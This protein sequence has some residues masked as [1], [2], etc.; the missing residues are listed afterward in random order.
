[1][2]AAYQVCR[3]GH[4]D[5][6]VASQRKRQPDEHDDIKEMSVEG[7]EYEVK[8]DRCADAADYRLI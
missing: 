3:E 6:C 7:V 1:M 5:N 8:G 2:I 4:C